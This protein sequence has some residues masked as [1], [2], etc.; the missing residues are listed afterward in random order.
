MRFRYEVVIEVEEP[1]FQLLKSQERSDK[2][3]KELMEQL[4]TNT[5]GYKFSEGS[6][7]CSIGLQPKPSKLERVINIIK[8]KENE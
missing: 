6:L 8:E 3:Q 2:I 7:V 1:G 4:C 5:L